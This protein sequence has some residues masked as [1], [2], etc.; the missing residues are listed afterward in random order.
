MFTN[1]LQSRVEG[2]G[3]AERI[4]HPDA[5]TQFTILRLIEAFSPGVETLMQDFQSEKIF[6]VRNTILQRVPGI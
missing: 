3:T 4:R 2:S 6:G 5:A 1:L